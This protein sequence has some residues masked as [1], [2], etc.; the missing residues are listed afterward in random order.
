ME[1]RMTD[2]AVSDLKVA[3]AVVRC[4]QKCDGAFND[5]VVET[6]Q[7]MPD[8]DWKALKRGVGQIRAGD[9]FD[10]WAALVSKHPQFNVAAFGQ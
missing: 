8:T 10:L 7:M 9:M 6:Q 1:F 3:E 2:V 5:L 4:L